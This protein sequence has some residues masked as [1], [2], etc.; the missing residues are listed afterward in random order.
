T[1]ARA[2]NF[3]LAF[4]LCCYTE[5]W[6]QFLIGKKNRFHGYN[7]KCFNE[8]FKRLGPKYEFL[9]RYNHNNY[10]HIKCDH[11][12]YNDIGVILI[13]TIQLWGILG[14]VLYIIFGIMALR[15]KPTLTILM[16]K[17]FIRFQYY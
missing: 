1:S 2:P 14:F 11:N 5:Y 6:G 17:I 9:I 13:L 12:I 8:F 15:E 10:D 4:A 7:R 16:S 3:L